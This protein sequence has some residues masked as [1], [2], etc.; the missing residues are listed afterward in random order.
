MEPL[1]LEQ[2]SYEIQALH[3]SMKNIIE[4]V[5]ATSPLLALS[6]RGWSWRTVNSTYLLR[7]SCILVGF[8]KLLTIFKVFISL[9]NDRPQI[10]VD[11]EDRVLESII[12][13]S[14]GQLTENVLDTL[15]SQVSI[16]EKDLSSDNDAMNWFNLL[17]TGF[18]IPPTPP[19]SIFPS[20]PSSGVSLYFELIPCFMQLTEI[21]YKE[22]SKVGEMYLN[23]D[24]RLNGFQG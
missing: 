24:I 16:L 23:L 4:I 13:I 6:T 11:L 19:A 9:G 22:N 12:A 21:L 8:W 15:H 10:L 14:E 20:T 5:F 2:I 3:K 7:V 17:T 1:Q 18:S